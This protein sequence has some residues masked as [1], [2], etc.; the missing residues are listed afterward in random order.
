MVQ[1]KGFETIEEAKTFRKENGGGLICW[2]ERTP[3]RKEL[4]SKG[5]AYMDCVKLGGLDPEKY[6]YCVQWTI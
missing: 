3:K 4:T 5:M 6:P 2:E 1:F